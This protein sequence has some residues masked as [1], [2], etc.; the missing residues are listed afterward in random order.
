MAIT[1]VGKLQEV[2]KMSVKVNIDVSD[3]KKEM[4]RVRA[5][6]NS[7]AF[8]EIEDRMDYSVKTLKIV[9][10]VD[11]GKA[12][13]GWSYKA[14]RDRKNAF[15][16]GFIKNDVSYISQLNNGT[17]KQAPKYFIEQVLS[18]IGILTPD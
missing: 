16:S 14:N 15:L 13:S 7:M 8:D 10:P 18:T 5:E 6:V 4:R 1:Q 17:S 9:T 2:L 12:R 11:T 3:F